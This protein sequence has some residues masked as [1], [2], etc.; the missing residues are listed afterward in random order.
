MRRLLDGLEAFITHSA[1][2]TFGMAVFLTAVCDRLHM[3]F[4]V[5]LCGAIA[6]ISPR[7]AVGAQ[8]KED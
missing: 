5:F 7:P 2:R 1:V 3:G 6:F 4:F 8:T